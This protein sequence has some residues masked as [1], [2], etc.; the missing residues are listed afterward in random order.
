[1]GKLFKFVAGLAVTGG[2]LAALTYHLQKK[3]V[4]NIEVNYDDAEGN[5]VT[6]PIDQIVDEAVVDIK[7]KAATTVQDLSSKA[8]AVAK[9][10]SDSAKGQFVAF[11]AK[12]G[13]SFKAGKS[14]V[15]SIASD[16]E[17]EL[18]GGVGEI[19][20][21]VSELK[22]AAENEV[23]KVKKR[24]TRVKKALTDPIE[25]SEEKED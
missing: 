24:A 8:G 12:L 13:D 10:V 25:E 16:A 14:K 11:S 17:S 20:E 21:S 1:M 2:A 9:D 15:A 3:G 4:V 7:D 22:D 18:Q 19:K 5:P 6:K 23:S